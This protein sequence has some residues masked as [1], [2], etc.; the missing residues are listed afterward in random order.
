M[1]STKSRRYRRETAART[2]CRTRS[3]STKPALTS[4]RP[5]SIARCPPPWARTRTCSFAKGWRR[6]GAHELP[7]D[8]GEVADVVLPGP[9]LDAGDRLHVDRRDAGH[10]EMGHAALE[11]SH[12]EVEL[13]PEQEDPRVEAAERLDR[14]PP[15]ERRA[16]PEAQDPG[17]VVVAEGA[18][19]LRALDPE[20]HEVRS[21]LLGPR[22]RPAQAVALQVAVVVEHEDPLAPGD[23]EGSVPCRDAFV[24]LGHAETHL[25]EAAADH[26]GGPLRGRV[27]DNDDVGPVFGVLQLAQ[28]VGEGQR[29]AA[30]GGCRPGWRP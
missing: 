24:S 29:P 22:D 23:G 20:G 16:A 21:R 9:D 8:V 5:A 2:G 3:P 30:R 10:D 4:G 7:G 25:R 12:G 11:R 28:D 6:R 27:V 18:A 13:V 26:L 19:R 14:P 17:L 1:Y 15:R